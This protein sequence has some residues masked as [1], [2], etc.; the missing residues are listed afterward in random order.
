[1]IL[2]VAKSYETVLTEYNHAEESPKPTTAAAESTHGTPAIPVA[3]RVAG[4]VVHVWL[5]DLCLST[6]Q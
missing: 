3:A 6:S 2:R 1:M 5:V 4:L